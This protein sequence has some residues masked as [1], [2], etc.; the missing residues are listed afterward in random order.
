MNLQKPL[1]VIFVGEEAVDE[2]GSYS[3]ILNFS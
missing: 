3:Y 2:V 1:K